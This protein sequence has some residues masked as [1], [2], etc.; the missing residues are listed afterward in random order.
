MEL[1]KQLSTSHGKIM[2]EIGP[3]ATGSA[4]NKAAV[5]Y[6]AETFRSFRL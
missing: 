2:S 4:G 3:R 6:A 5:D 1:S